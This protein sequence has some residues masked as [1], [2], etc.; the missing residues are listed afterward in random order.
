[1]PGTVG[2]RIDFAFSARRSPAW[3]IQQAFGA[4]G[5][6][7][8]APGPFQNTIPAPEASFLPEANIYVGTHK[9]SDQPWNDSGRFLGNCTIKEVAGV[10]N[11]YSAGNG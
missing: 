9:R 1:M 5:Y 6:G 8:D 7:T 11:T 10:L 4:A 2:I 3:T